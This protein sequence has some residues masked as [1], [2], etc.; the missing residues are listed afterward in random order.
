MKDIKILYISKSK[1]PAKAKIDKLI[2]IGVY[3]LS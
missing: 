2:G 1:D 3:T